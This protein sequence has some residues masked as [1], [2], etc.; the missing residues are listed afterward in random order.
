MKKEEM[1]SLNK[2]FEAEFEITELE[3]RLETDP[4]VFIDILMQNIEAMPCHE[5]YVKCGGSY[6]FCD[7]G[8]EPDT[9]DDVYLMCH[10]G[11]DTVMN[12]QNHDTVISLQNMER[13]T[14]SVSDTIKEADVALLK[15]E[16]FN[17]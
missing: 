5:G 13:D 17:R 3:Q 7:G 8:Y 4:W 15:E 6:K 11:Y 12:L 10:G 9:C 16:L 14:V 1:I 2:S